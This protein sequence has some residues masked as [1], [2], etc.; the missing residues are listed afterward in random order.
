MTTSAFPPGARLARALACTLILASG[1]CARSD[2]YTQRTALLNDDGPFLDD[3]AATRQRELETI[4]AGFVPAEAPVTTPIRDASGAVTGRSFSTSADMQHRLG[5]ARQSAFGA[6]EGACLRYL[7][8]VFWAQRGKQTTGDLVSIAASQLPLLLT[9]AGT[10]Q[11]SANALASAIGLG[12]Q[13]YDEL[14]ETYLYALPPSALLATVEAS[15]QQFRNELFTN[16]DSATVESLG[17][18]ARQVQAYAGHCTPVRLEAMA[19]ALIES[20]AQAFAPLTPDEAAQL[21][22]L[23]K[24]GEGSG[25]STAEAQTLAALAGRK[26]HAG[27]LDVGSQ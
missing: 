4:L 18:L 17:E 16:T 2:L 24:K 11:A 3:A 1:A 20:G 7:D 21:E 14:M 25:L 22:T 13:I 8:A 12:G 5:L 6:V 27:L 26:K 23:L 19:T 9:T 15:A 10:A